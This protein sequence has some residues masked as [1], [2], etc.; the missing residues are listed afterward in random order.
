LTINIYVIVI[1]ICDKY[2]RRILDRE[3][4]KGSAELLIITL[5]ETR[6]PHGYEISMVS[7]ADALS[8]H[9]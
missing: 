6:A 1:C 8:P 2:N 7:V 5:V 3:L 4:K 9:G